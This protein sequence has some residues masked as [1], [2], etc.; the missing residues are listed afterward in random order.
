MPCRCAAVRGR[1]ATMIVVTTGGVSICSLSMFQALFRSTRPPDEQKS[2]LR[3][4]TGCRS[5][6]RRSWEQRAVEAMLS[7]CTSYAIVLAVY[8]GWYSNT[9]GSAISAGTMIIGR[10]GNSE[11][12]RSCSQAS[13]LGVHCDACAAGCEVQV[14]SSELSDS[15]SSNRKCHSHDDDWPFDRQRNSQCANPLTAPPLVRPPLPPPGLLAPPARPFWAPHSP[16]QE[17]AF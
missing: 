15:S 11:G 14:Q 1:T 6:Q 13:K 5:R 8:L 3:R 2:Q 9:T 10:K 17:V 4:V 7:T 16:Q 12:V